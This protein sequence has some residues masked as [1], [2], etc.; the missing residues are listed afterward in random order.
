MA[1]KFNRNNWIKAKIRFISLRYPPRTE[2]KRLARVERGRYKCSMC[3]VD[4][5]RENEIHIDHINPVVP[6]NNDWEYGSIDWGVYI[7]NLFC[8][9]E[10]L[11]ALCITCHSSKSQ[12]EDAMRKKFR[13]IKREKKKLDKKLKE[14]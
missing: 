9:V 3:Q 8:D 14:E 13:E 6:L 1:K 2:A 4:T 11:Q 7:P 10:N 12:I 5:F